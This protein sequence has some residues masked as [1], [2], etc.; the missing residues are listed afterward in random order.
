M[1]AIRTSINRLHPAKRLRL[2]APAT[3]ILYSSP[4]SVV[5][6]SRILTPLVNSFQSVRSMASE[7]A[8]VQCPA[9][10]WEA[11]AVVNGEFKKIKLSDY[12]GRYLVMVFYPLDFTFVCPTELIA[13]SDRSNEFKS[14]GAEIVGI[15]V[16]SEY[17][18]LAWCNT[19]RNKGGLGDMKIPLVSDLTKEISRKYNVLVPDGSVAMRGLFIIDPKGVLRIAHINDLPIGRNVDE[20]LRLVEALQFHE[21]HG[22]VCPAGWSKQNPKTMKADPQGAKAYF[23]STYK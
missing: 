1:H 8:R 14:I 21:K 18:H 19:P 4:T 3:S 12:A 11:T 22:E 2:S 5:P 10:A 16:D 9:P 17:S 20:A 7:V 15:S 23:E 13:F 6:S